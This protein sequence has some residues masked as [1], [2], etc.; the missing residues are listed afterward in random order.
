MHNKSSIL[1]KLREILISA[2]VP[3]VLALA[4]FLILT[5]ISLLIRLFRRDYLSIKFSNKKNSYWL[6]KKKQLENMNKLF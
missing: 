5:P 6:N 1:L 4:Y 2:L 3:S